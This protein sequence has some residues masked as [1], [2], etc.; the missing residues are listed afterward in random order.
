[1]GDIFVERLTRCCV[2]RAKNGKKAVPDKIN[3]IKLC[4][5]K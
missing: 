1:M 4:S 2:E 3:V 5:V